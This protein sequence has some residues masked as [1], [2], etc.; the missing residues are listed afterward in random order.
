MSNN[1]HTRL[2]LSAEDRGIS[3]MMKKMSTE[4]S[5]TID[6]FG[7]L[8]STIAAALGGLTAGAGLK[9]A[10]GWIDEY[11]NDVL[12]IAVTLT[13]TVKGS[14]S[15]MA[16]ALDQNK[17]HAADFFKLLQV[18][19]AKS[20]SS[21]SDLTKAYTL[22]ASQGLALDPTAESAGM[23]A[24]VTDRIKMLTQ[25]QQSDIQIRQEIRSM[26]Q[27][28]S[29]ATDALAQRLTNLDPDFLKKIKSYVSA[30]QGQEAM[31][32]LDSLLPTNISG[33]ISSLLSKQLERVKTNVRLWTLDAFSPLYDEVKAIVSSV[34]DVFAPGGDSPIKSGMAML[35]QDLTKVVSGL[36]DFA[37]QVSNS[38]FTNFFLLTGPRLAAI[39]LAA[40]TAAK[41]FG[42]LKMAIAASVGALAT[43]PGM[44]TVGV[45]AV[46]AGG[47]WSQQQMTRDQA[48]GQTGGEGESWQETKSY[49]ADMINGFIAFSKGLLSGA[50]S[51]I[52]GLI[53]AVKSSA[54]TL[55]GD[56]LELVAKAMFKFNDISRT[57]ISVFYDLKNGAAIV[58]E[59]IKWGISKG[60]EALYSSMSKAPFGIGKA[61]AIAAEGAAAGSAAATIRIAELEA[62]KKPDA[63]PDVFAE[64]INWALG[65]S[66][67]LKNQG[68]SAWA[69]LADPKNMLNDILDASIDDWDKSQAK[70]R[71]SLKESAVGVAGTKAV[72]G[73]RS[74][75]IGLQAANLEDY[76]KQIA[77]LIK[78]TA[79]LDKVITD[80]DAAIAKGGN[81]Y[82]SAMAQVTKQYNSQQLKIAKFGGEQA[83]ALSDSAKAMQELTFLNNELAELKKAEN[84]AAADQITLIQKNIAE[85]QEQAAQQAI[86]AMELL[87]ADKDAASAR[88][89]LTLE[90]FRAEKTRQV[91]I[92][93]ADA[94]SQRVSALGGFTSG[95]DSGRSGSNAYN[96]KI[97]ESVELQK[98]LIDFQRQ[99]SGSEESS[100]DA[101]DRLNKLSKEYQQTL[102]QATPEIE[103]QIQAM[104]YQAELMSKDTMFSGIQGGLIEMDKRITSTYEKWSEMTVSVF[105]S[106]QNTMSNFFFDFFSGNLDSAKDYFVAWGQSITQAFSDM[107]AKMVVDYIASTAAMQAVGGALKL[108]LSLAGAFL[109]IGSA[110][111]GGVASAS[112]EIGS[113]SLGGAGAAGPGSLTAGWANGGIA[114]GG[115]RAFSDGG[116]VTTPTL[117]LV[118]E[119]RYN[120]A[121]VPLPDGRSIPVEMRGGRTEQNV[122]INVIDN[123]GGETKKTINQSQDEQGRTLIDII[124][125]AA[126]RNKNG[127]RG[128][129]RN[130]LGVS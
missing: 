11:R 89:R 33:E 20:L 95:L 59:Q 16:A 31:K 24:S 27:G 117:G 118:G 120:E 86:V 112:S 51:L 56:I 38:A 94:M 35:A 74:S 83:N 3:T 108:G 107:L 127:F 4:T 29:R 18:Q 109:G 67:S 72:V 52:I 82:Q 63:K 25:G 39:A 15:E 62:A 124:L 34:A 116:M 81:D 13:D 84:E 8:G 123:T 70:R 45:M 90:R 19:S 99:G 119:G 36:K 54:L 1:M 43:I 22:F 32:Y 113:I 26:L 9:T 88:A 2:I 28:R 128:Q 111:V 69:G 61:A 76:N 60:L 42:L 49:I 30:G 10:L 65:Q 66:A 64:S 129:L 40:L 92:E 46:A 79:G 101:K 71:L 75:I 100:V 23:L 87:K 12:S 7:R 21:F 78:D 47:A 58:F 93:Q 126:N 104:E 55:A 97:K 125:D 103:R 106:M 14:S 96:Q 48:K 17:R 121:I 91:N 41:A 130:A 102:A 6:Q 85:K 122:I 110:A 114:P 77:K 37:S 105:S 68:A 44:I 53:E 50:I 80:L 73:D 57:I 98:Q 115:F 5:A